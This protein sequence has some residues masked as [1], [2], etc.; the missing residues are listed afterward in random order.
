MQVMSGFAGEAT[1]V[2]SSES[3]LLERLIAEPAPAT[4]AT[5]ATHSAPPV[6]H[7][8][9]SAYTGERER[10]Y[11]KPCAIQKGNIGIP[12]TLQKE[13]IQN[14]LIYENTGNVQTKILS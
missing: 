11:K 6:C 3:A 12:L 13:K 1:S 2:S 4:A 8:Q 9:V 14:Y 5:P 10:G 7:L